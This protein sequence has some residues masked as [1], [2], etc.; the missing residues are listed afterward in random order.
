MVRPSRWCDLRAMTAVGDHKASAWPVV[1]ALGV[2]ALH[3]AVRSTSG[4][5]WF[6]FTQAMLVVSWLSLLLLPVTF[7]LARRAWAHPR[8]RLILAGSVGFVVLSAF[9]PD[10]PDDYRT[11]FLG[12]CDGSPAD[13][14]WW[15]A[16]DPLVGILPFVSLMASFL[17]CLFMCIAIPCA[18]VVG[19]RLQS[20]S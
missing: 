14:A 11:C 6:A 20:A 13:T 1:V 10:N 12:A 5:G 2:V 17:A 8:I 19:S 9:T 16:I 3:V 15:A 18:L 7:H 4:F